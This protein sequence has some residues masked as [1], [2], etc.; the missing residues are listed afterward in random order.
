MTQVTNESWTKVVPQRPPG[1]LMAPF[2]WAAKPLAAMLEADSSLYPAPVTSLLQTFDR[3][4]RNVLEKM[5]KEKQIK[6]S[7]DF[8]D[9]LRNVDEQNITYLED[10]AIELDGKQSKFVAL[11]NSSGYKHFQ[12]P[13]FHYKQM[14][15]VDSYRDDV[16]NAPHR[17]FVKVFKLAFEQTGAVW[18]TD[19]TWNGG[20]GLI[21]DKQLHYDDLNFGQLYSKGINKHDH[22]YYQ[23]TSYG[24]EQRGKP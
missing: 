20:D 18:Q 1:Y 2:G 17:I 21:S 15:V 24:K 7:N 14:L 5:I 10:W 9:D 6:V 22:V 3:E 12:H 8:Q 19:E 16:T 23:G 4:A 11:R 13:E